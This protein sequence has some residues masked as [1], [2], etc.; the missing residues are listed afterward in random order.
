MRSA[1][2]WLILML[3]AAASLP[4]QTPGTGK[5]V[6]DAR[7]AICH[8]ED[9]N[10]GEFAPGIV[11]RI[12]PRTDSEIAA[13]VRNGLPSRGMPEVQ[14][15]DQALGDLVAYLRTLRPPRR[16]ELAAVPVTID[17]TDA[18]KLS[19]IAVNQ[20]FED[21]QLR[22]A[23][24][25]IHLLRREGPRFREV[26]SQVDWS[27]YDGQLTANRFSALK[28][29][30]KTNVAKLK[31]RWIFSMPDTPSS[32]MTPLVHQGIMYVT[33]GNECYALDAGTG[34]QIWRYQRQR[35]KG[36]AVRVNRGAAIAGDRVF[37][38]T[39]DAG[40]IA[41]NRF[42]G[43]LLWDTV[44][45]DPRQNYFATSAPLI[46][47]DLV[48]P[49]IGGGDSG[50]RGFLAAFDQKTGKEVWRFWTIPSAGEAG[51]ETWN[52]KGLA[53]PGGATWFT[54][55]FDPELNL[56][57][58][59]V[60]NPGPDHNGDQREGDN[61][62]SDSVVALDVRTGKLKWHYQFTPHDVWDW[63]AQEPLVLVDTVWEGQPRKLMLQANRNGFFYVLD[64]TNGKLLLGKP[65]V[66]KLTWAKEI[67]PNGRPVKNSDQEPTEKGTRICP[68]VLGAT[69]WWSAAFDPSSKLYYIQTIESCGIFL[70]R[71]GE[72]E[73]GRGFMGG[74]SRNAPSDPP[75]RI[76][77]AIDINTGRSAWELPQVGSGESRSGT[78][79]TAAGLVFFGEDSGAL[80]AA[81][82]ATGKPLWGFQTSQSLRASP[83]TYLFDNKQLV[84]LASGS[85]ILVFGLMD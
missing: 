57:Y 61:L 4:A 41:L 2:T 64:R 23:D 34:R 26:T 37:M 22:T 67:G 9:A 77:R 20:S 83:M 36:Q 17:T 50:V 24:G 27:T 32:E 51:S 53:H 5:Q 39:E 65:F 75:K 58:W 19:G 25:R 49:G 76:L 79:A 69:N 10:G 47:G 38:T 42:T 21:M 1:S 7:C 63:D 16:G 68:A 14:L 60:G 11:T 28:Q 56:L 78:L 15:S 70:K 31:P 6:F 73:A 33:S 43:E 72:W 45:A 74:S 81:D 55:S 8:G 46:A 85:N 3:F 40:L 48:I 80:M 52:G 84:G 18:R 35:P 29:I 13:V 12:A 30:D 54:G 82:S 71:G 59:Q 44:M 66:S 62:Y